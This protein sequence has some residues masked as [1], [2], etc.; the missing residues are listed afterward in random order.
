MSGRSVLVLVVGLEL[1]RDTVT[2]TGILCS[3]SL[4]SR[5]ER[6]VMI[7]KTLTGV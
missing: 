3:L 7:N 4:M 5:C 1:H 2:E 6:R